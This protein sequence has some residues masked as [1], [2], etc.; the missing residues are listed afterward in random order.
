M[1]EFQQKAVADE[2]KHNA[3]IEKLRQTNADTEAKLAKTDAEIDKLRAETAKILSS[4]GLDVR[5]QDLDEYETAAAQQDKAID[6][7][8]AVQNRSEDRQQQLLQ[9]NSGGPAYS[10]VFTSRPEVRRLGKEC[11]SMCRS[12]GSSEH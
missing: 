12:R 5:K 6:R 9:S 11:V 1:A 8:I 3:E 7:T 4:I 2:A 10:P